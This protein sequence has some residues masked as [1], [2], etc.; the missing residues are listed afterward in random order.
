MSPLPPYSITFLG[1]IKHILLTIHQLQM[2]DLRF[3]R[4]G[5]QSTPWPLSSQHTSTRPYLTFP[6]YSPDYFSDFDV[7]KDLSLLASGMCPLF[8]CIVVS[9]LR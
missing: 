3:A 8:T 6:Q 2:Y 5:I 4:H 7:C 1:T 9:S